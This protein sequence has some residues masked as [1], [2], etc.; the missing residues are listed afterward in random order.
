MSRAVAKWTHHY[1]GQW[2]TLQDWRHIAIAISKKHARQR[3]AAKADFEDTGN[4]NNKEQYEI[5]DDLA[6]SHMGQT[7]ANYSVTIDVLKRLTADSLE[8]FE[9]VSHQWHKFLELVEQPSSQPALKRKGAVDVRELTPLKQL[10]VLHLEKPNLEAS[11]DQ[12]I[13][14]ALQT[15]L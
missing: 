6:A 15:V 5:P 9:Q 8:I 7:A 14:Q 3:G 1:M 12:L 4:S 11:K 10:K 2:I 13:L